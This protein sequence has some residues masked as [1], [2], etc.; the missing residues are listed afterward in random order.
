[1]GNLSCGNLDPPPSSGG[2]S[3]ASSPSA[4]HEDGLTKRFRRCRSPFREPPKSDRHPVGMVIAIISESRSPSVRNR[5]RHRREC[6]PVVPFDSGRQFLS[7]V[8]SPSPRPTASQ[9]QLGMKMMTTCLRR[10]ENFALE[11]L[12]TSGDGLLA[13]R[14]L[15]LEV[16]PFETTAHPCQASIA[17]RSGRSTPA[18]VSCTTTNGS[19]LSICLP[20]IECC[21]KTLL[22]NL[23]SLRSY[24]K[25]NAVFGTSLSIISR[26]SAI[27]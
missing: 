11:T 7:T 14:W 19:S 22:I 8:R 5:D 12:S 3:A 18:A 26:S 21:T 10:G 2:Q 4:L 20:P 27:W 6:A 17:F 15:G 9:F 24:T 25:T 1:M 13:K 16:A 23:N